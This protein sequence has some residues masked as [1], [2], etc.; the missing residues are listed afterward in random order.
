MNNHHKPLTRRQAEVLQFIKSFVSKNGYPP[1]V[2]EI[3]DHMHYQSASTA[4]QLLEVLE[5]KGYITKSD[6]PRTIKVIEQ[7]GLKKSEG[8]GRNDVSR[9]KAAL[10]NILDISTDEFSRSQARY[11]LNL[12]GKP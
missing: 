11:G 9:M 1:T 8:Y 2:R 10:Q 7:E 5:K 6:S 12:G 4:F 3:A